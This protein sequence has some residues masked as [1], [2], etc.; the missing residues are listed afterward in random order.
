[1]SLEDSCPRFVGDDAEDLSMACTSDKT[2]SEKTVSDN[3]VDEDRGVWQPASR[4]I[5]HRATHS[6]GS[7][8]AGRQ[9]DDI[10]AEKTGRSLEERKGSNIV[11]KVNFSWQCI[12]TLPYL[13][14]P[15]HITVFSQH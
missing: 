9:S 14:K 2:A 12:P 6:R 13:Q 8:R 15:C 3:T 10:L 7:I 1:M 5:V 4:L 11:S